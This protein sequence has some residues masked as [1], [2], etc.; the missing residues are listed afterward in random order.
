MRVYHFLSSRYA[1]N[2]LKRRRLKIATFDDLNDPFDLWSVAQPDRSVRRGLRRWKVEMSAHYG[3]ICFSQDWQNPVLWS[4]YADRHRGIVLRFEVNDEM[5]Q[6]VTYVS[7]RPALRGIDMATA[8]ALLFTKY[9]D[10][11]YEREPGYLPA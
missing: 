8:Q 9:Q 2:D 5:L 7:A 6:E 4:H 1:I 10:W 3:M 11:Q